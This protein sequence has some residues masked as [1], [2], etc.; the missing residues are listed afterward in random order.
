MLH[1]DEK[2]VLNTLENIIIEYSCSDEFEE[3][4]SNVHAI[5]GLMRHFEYKL[6]AYFEM[7]HRLIEQN[8][9]KE[10]EE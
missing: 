9:L 1:I 10:E 6:M 4:T 2:I 8:P 5:Y 7:Y 3:T